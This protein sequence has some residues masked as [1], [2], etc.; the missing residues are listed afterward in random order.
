MTYTSYDG[1][2][3]LC[4]ATSEDLVQWTKHGPA[5]AAMTEHFADA[6]SK[7][8]SIVVRAVRRENGDVVMVAAR[9]SD[10]L[11]R[12]YWG[13]NDIYSGTCAFRLPEEIF[14]ALLVQAPLTSR[15]LL[16]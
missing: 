2:A 16:T 7:S 12:M 11:F 4:V 13:E 5:F 6:W 14:V 1:K 15:P 8:G 9:L 3:R 10:G